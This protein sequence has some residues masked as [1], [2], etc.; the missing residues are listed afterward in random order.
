MKGNKTVVSRSMNGTNNTHAACCNKEI[1]TCYNFVMQTWRK[2]IHRHKSVSWLIAAAVVILTLTPL[3]M[4]LHHDVETDT[5]HAVGHISPDAHGHTSA[6]H[7][8]T[9]T[10]GHDGHDEVTV[11]SVMSDSLVKKNSFNPAFL[12]VL[13]SI[14]VF[15]ALALT[16]HHFRPLVAS[17]PRKWHLSLSPPLRAPPA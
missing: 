17:V 10:N 16:S 8:V 5:S 1:R 14:F 2:F 3:H 12:A 15:L 7:T 11:I 4:H 6:V 13:V 9:D